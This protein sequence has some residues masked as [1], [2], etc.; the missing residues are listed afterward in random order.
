MPSRL[1]QLTIAGI[2]AAA[3]RRQTTNSSFAALRKM[4][5]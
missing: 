1:C 3:K 5:F 2:P 4:T